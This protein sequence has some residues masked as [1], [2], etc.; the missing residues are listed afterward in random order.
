MPLSTAQDVDT[1]TSAYQF[2]VLDADGN[3]YDLAQRRGFPTLFFNSASSCGL[4]KSSFENARKLHEKYKDVGFLPMSF[5]S[6]SFFQEPL[7]SFDAKKFGCSTYRIEFP[8]MGKV[9]VN[10]SDACPLWKWL[11]KEKTGFLWTAFIKF[12][13]TSFLVDGD[14][15]VVERFS[16]GISADDI[17]EILL[18]LLE[19]SKI[20]AKQKA[21]EEEEKKRGEK[22]REEMKKNVVEQEAATTT[23]NNGDDE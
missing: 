5:P 23:K 8:T 1:A 4:A 10:G 2:T 19:Q 16:P 15:K 6:S 9:E 14:G 20:Q 7:A 21:D 3:E 13:Y 22:E 17:E 12:N 18:P 11:Q